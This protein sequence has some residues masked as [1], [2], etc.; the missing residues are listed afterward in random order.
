[1]ALSDHLRE[2]RARILK[3]ALVLLVG[4]IVAL[5]FFD[6]IFAIINE[7]YQKA[8]ESLGAERTMA[9]TSGVAG[10]FILY[11]KLCGLAA[12][13]GTSPIWLYQIW[14]F[15]LPGLH[16][17]EKRWTALFAV[18]AG[19]LFIGGIVLAYVTL[20]KGLEILI[21]FTQAD[22][23]NLVE[24]NDYLSFFTRTMLVFGVAFEIPVFV[25][26]LNMA[27]ILRGKALGAVRPWIVIGC[28][29]FA[30][31]ATPSTDPF[32]MTFMAVPMVV[33]FFVS[34]VI[35]RLNDRRRDKNRINA[36][37]SPDEA[38]PLDL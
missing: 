12:V 37:L 20:P 8:R 29:V 38:S 36:G 24:F 19:P 1:M 22:L 3:A 10:G 6:P 9:T 28:F 27:G 13:I 16:R 30:A 2:L 18:I 35:A 21:G 4:F 31:A 14:A 23:T 25:V 26:L 34:E 7:P 11:L 32:T 17:T 5:F 15:I 33:L